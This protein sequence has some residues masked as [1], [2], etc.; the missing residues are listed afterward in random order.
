LRKLDLALEGAEVDLHVEV[1]AATGAA[2]LARD[3]E[4]LV[5]GVE[6][7]VVR[8]DARQLDDHL[9]LVRVF[10]PHDVELR[11]EAAAEAGEARNL[12]ELVDELLH[13]ALQPVDGV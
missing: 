7:D 8:V 5:V 11:P 12:P 6:I 4:R 10:G 9:E 13:L 2:T 1:A 3:D